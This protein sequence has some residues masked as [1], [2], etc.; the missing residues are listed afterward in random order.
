MATRRPNSGCQP[1]EWLRGDRSA[2]R[3]AKLIRVERYEGE[4][5]LLEV[6]FQ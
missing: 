5:G 3:K 4:I 6:A 1:K 2:N